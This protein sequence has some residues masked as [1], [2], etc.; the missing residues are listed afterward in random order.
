[1]PNP[2]PPAPTAEMAAQARE[3]AEAAA[4]EHDIGIEDVCVAISPI[5]GDKR[6]YIRSTAGEFEPVSED[7]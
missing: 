2:T 1:M 4:S 3:L 7:A 6:V 5:T